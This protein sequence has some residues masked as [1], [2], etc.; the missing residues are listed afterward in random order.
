LQMRLNA[1]SRPFR[2]RLLFLFR[3]ILPLVAPRVPPFLSGGRATYD[4]PSCS[5]RPEG[6]YTR[7]QFLP[8]AQLNCAKNREST[9]LLARSLADRTILSS[10]FEP[11]SRAIA[12]SA[13]SNRRGAFLPFPCPALHFL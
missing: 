2:D 3:T 6:P 7:Q 4:C 11:G 12:P 13:D 5:R 10:A 9:P 1:L 8:L